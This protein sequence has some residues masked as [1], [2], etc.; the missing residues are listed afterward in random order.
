[1]LLQAVLALD[2]HPTVS[3]LA[4]GSRDCTVKFYD[5]SKPSVKRSYRSITDVVGINS[6]HF[7]PSGDYMLV[8]TAQSTRKGRR[9]KEREREGGGGRRKERDVIILLILLHSSSLWCW[10]P[11][12]F[13]V[14]WLSRPASWCHN[15]C[16]LFPRWSPLH[17]RQRRWLHQ[18]QKFF[19]LKIVTFF[20][21]FSYD[22]VTVAVILLC[23]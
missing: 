22:Y 13:C 5:Y 12:V 20:F 7:H 8:G 1:M 14:F 6:I 19:W 15:V 23:F 11:P 18:G 10:Y 9:K 2:F 21:I 4:S 3:V 16:S 17:H